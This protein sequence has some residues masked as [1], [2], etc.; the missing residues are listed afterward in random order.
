MKID[1]DRVE[2]VTP[3]TLIGDLVLFHPDKERIVS[4]K[5]HSK[6]SNSPYVGMRLPGVIVHTIC[7]GKI[8]YS[9][10]D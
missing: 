6:S 7:S 4:P 10:N 2:T 8:V 9:E 3:N 1:I 5:F